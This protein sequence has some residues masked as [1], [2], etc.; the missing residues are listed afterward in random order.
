MKGYPTSVRKLFGVGKTHILV[1]RNVSVDCV[2]EEF[3]FSPYN[4]LRAGRKKN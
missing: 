2:K 4:Q 3:A 1:T